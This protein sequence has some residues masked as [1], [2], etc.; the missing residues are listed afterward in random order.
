MEDVADSLQSNSYLPKTLIL[1]TTL[2][3]TLQINNQTK[4]TCDQECACFVLQASPNIPA[5]VLYDK[6]DDGLNP[7]N[8]WAG[9]YVVLNPAY[10]AQVYA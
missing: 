1:P 8:S 2:K 5:E 4:I 9:F 6:R 3:P 10:Q 7:E